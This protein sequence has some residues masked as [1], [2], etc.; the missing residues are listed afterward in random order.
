MN[1]RTRT[2]ITAATTGILALT[3]GVATPAIA[4]AA[5][6]ANGTTNTTNAA[7]V[8]KST[9]ANRVEVEPNVAI[10]T[11]NPIA[12][13]A[14][15]NTYYSSLPSSGKNEVYKVTPAGIKQTYTID[16]SSPVVAI[17]GLAIGPDGTLDALIEV[18]P[19]PNDVQDWLF[20]ADQSSMTL[21]PVRQFLSSTVENPSPYAGVAVNPLTGAIAYTSTN[22]QM[23]LSFLPGN[24]NAPRPLAGTGTTGFTGDGGPATVSRLSNPRLT[25]AVG[26]PA[27]TPLGR[28]NR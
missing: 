11:S 12:T 16:T 19:N 26:E 9:L 10:G 4:S 15:G 22:L 8:F 24:T 7:P 21:T 17:R 2:C 14:A 13:D 28:Y 20:S 5:V 3:I 25:C 27:A 1:K 18:N 23:I 6:T